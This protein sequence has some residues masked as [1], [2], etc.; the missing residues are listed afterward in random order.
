MAYA[1]AVGP[2]LQPILHRLPYPDP[3]ER[4]RVET[5]T[6]GGA[7]SLAY[8]QG[9]GVGRVKWLGGKRAVVLSEKGIHSVTDLLFHIPRSTSIDRRGCGSTR[10]RRGWR[11]P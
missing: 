8:L 6:E 10:S 4:Q 7:R 5:G 2:G 11:P 1:V 9:I 3:M